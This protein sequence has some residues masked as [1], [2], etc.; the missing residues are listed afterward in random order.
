MQPNEPA[1]GPAAPDP[2]ALAFP[3]TMDANC[4]T[5]RCNTALGR[6]AWPCQ[7]DADCQPNTQCVTP[8]CIPIIGQRPTP[9]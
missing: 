3:C 1:P 8:A 7:S 9:N 2:S 6:C 5:H 4:L